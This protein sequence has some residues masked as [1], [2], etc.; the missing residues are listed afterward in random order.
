MA[1]KITTSTTSA[2]PVAAEKAEA[3]DLFAALIGGLKAE[4]VTVKPR[5]NP[6]GTYASL[7][8]GKKNVGYVFK[9]SRRGMRIEP[10]ASKDDLAKGSK[11]FKPGK[12]SAL[13]ALVG[14]VQSEADVPEAVAVLKTAASR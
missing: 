11:V 9:Q 6:K 7:L 5:W 12:R 1:R 13:F 4:G 8:V 3:P 14:N 2:K 10:A